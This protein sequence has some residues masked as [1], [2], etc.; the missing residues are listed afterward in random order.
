MRIV[1]VCPDIFFLFLSSFSTSS[2]LFST[3]S[4]LG[5]GKYSSIA[6]RLVKLPWWLVAN[7]GD[8]TETDGD[9]CATVVVDGVL[10]AVVGVEMRNFC[11]LFSFNPG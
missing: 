1:A 3:R 2:P 6:K 11:L 10:E 8:A 9:Y 4:A 7:S 5:S